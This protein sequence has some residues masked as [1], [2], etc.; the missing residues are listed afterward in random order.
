PSDGGGAE[1]P[2]WD[3]GQHVCSVGCV[4]DDSPQT[5]GTSCSPCLAPDNGGTATCVAGAC[6]GSCPTGKKLCA[7][8]CID[9]AATC[10]PTCRAASTHACGQLCP[11]TTDVNAC[12][13]SCKPC[14]VPLNATVATCNGTTCGFTCKSSFHACGA[15]CASDTDVG[16]CGD[17]CLVCPTDPHGSPVCAGG[18]CTLQCA[19]SYHSCG[20]KCVSDADVGSC[21]P[22]SCM[23]CGSITGGTATCDGQKCGGTCPA[24]QMLCNGACIAMNAPCAACP[25]GTHDCGGVCVDDKSTNSC[26]TL[27]SACPKPTGASATACTTGACDFT[28]SQGYHRCGAACAANDDATACGAT[29]VKCPT[30]A[31]GVASCQA[32]GTCSL[33]CNTGFHLCGGKCVSTKDL[34]NCGATSCGV[35]CTAPT[36]GT[37]SCDGVSCLPVCTNPNQYNCQGTCIDKAMACNGTCQVAGQHVCSGFCRANDTANCGPS[38]LTCPVPPLNGAASCNGTSCGIACNTNYRNCAGTNLCVATAAPACCASA[39]CTTTPTGTIGVC[40]NNVCTYPCNT[41]TYKT[42]GTACIPASACCTNMDCPAA[43]PL[44]SSGT[45]VGRPL[46]QACGTQTECASGACVDGVCCS[47]GSCPTC[48]ACNKNG[49]GTCSALP[50]AAAAGC[51][52]DSTNCTAGCDGAGKCKASAAGTSCAAAACANTSD[53]VGLIAHVGQYTAVSYQTKQCDGSANASAAC[54]AQPSTGCSGAFICASGGTACKTTCAT[55]ADCVLGYYCDSTINKCVVQHAGGVSCSAAMEC[56]SHDCNANATNVCLTMAVNDVAQ[57]SGNCNDRSG[58]LQCPSSATSCGADGS[59]HCGTGPACAPWMV[60]M[61]GVGCRVAG[62]Y[63]CLSATDCAYGTC[64][65]GLCPFAPD[66]GHCSGIGGPNGCSLCTGNG[67]T[68]E[69]DNNGTCDGYFTGDGN[70]CI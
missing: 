15:A 52:V 59:C 18:L 30:D 14:P 20:G 17:Q 22:S 1:I 13:T 11:S 4:H 47:T 44:C 37:V 50:A 7:G 54:K 69:C 25:G 56:Q 63:P 8:A 57:F 51:P 66:T 10:D 19:A 23:A 46:G 6:D 34:N 53:S 12:G 64:T 24:N 38:C 27:C 58:N 65:A 70:I 49:A 2:A 42:C 48:Q 61:P 45:C 68:G 9:T 55:H 5:C 62:R 32:N 60:C 3:P 33:S 41:P 35:A 43:K 36:G 31:N 21:G 40:S 28:C 16:A 67:G 29:C 26:G 39:E